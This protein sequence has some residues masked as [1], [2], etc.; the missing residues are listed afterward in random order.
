MLDC[1][2]IDVSAIGEAS[3]LTRSTAFEAKKANKIAEL[4]FQ[5]EVNTVK[6]EVGNRYLYYTFPCE[7][8]EAWLRMRDSVDKRK[9]YEEENQFSFLKNKIIEDFTVV[10]VDITK[11]MKYQSSWVV[12]FKYKKDSY[13][14]EFPIID[15]IN[16]NNYLFAN[17]GMIQLSKDMTD[18]STEHIIDSYNPDEIKEKFK[19]INGLEHIIE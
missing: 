12:W 14:L 11:I 15:E 5:N 19:A 6:H 2:K 17:R 10:N 7:K 9:K 18:L 3:E 16:T 4:A 8:A 1:M 13:N